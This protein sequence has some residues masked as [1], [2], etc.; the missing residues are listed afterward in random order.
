MSSVFTRRVIAYILDFIVISAFM[1]ILAYLC[2]FFVKPYEA[3]AFYKYFPYILPILIM[4]Y[5]VL[6][7]KIKGATIGKAMMYLEVRSR[8]GAKINWPQAIV[9]NLSKIYWFPI[10]FDWLIG[11]LLNSDRFL[12][13]FTRTVVVNELR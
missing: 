12:S 13:R 11:K 9:R 1:W 10:I 7:E 5:F 4:V 6:C 3:Y 2:S 8:N